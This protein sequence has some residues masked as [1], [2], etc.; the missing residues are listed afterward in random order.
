VN[1]LAHLVA[2]ALLEHETLD[3]AEVVAV[4]GLRDRA[5]HRDLEPIVPA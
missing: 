1:G 3:E 2:A 5:Q 4:T